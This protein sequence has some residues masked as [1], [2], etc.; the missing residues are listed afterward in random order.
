MKERKENSHLNFYFI[1]NRGYFKIM[2]QTITK[3]TNLKR[4]KL[5]NAHKNWSQIRER[6]LGKTNWTCNCLLSFVIWIFVFRRIWIHYHVRL[7][8]LLQM[9]I[10]FLHLMTFKGNDFFWRES[11]D[12]YLVLNKKVNL[13]IYLP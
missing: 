3:K 5:K 8:T 2:H 1:F 7:I 13:I 6:L 4:E 12:R 10:I 11:Y 9:V